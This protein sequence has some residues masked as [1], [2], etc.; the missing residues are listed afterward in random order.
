MGEVA[1]YVDE[2]TSAGTTD[3]V[4][5][6]TDEEL[7][8][9]GR[10]VRSDPAD[11]T[12]YEWWRT[13]TGP[14]RTGASPAKDGEPPDAVEG[15]FGTPGSSL[16]LTFAGGR[17]HESAFQVYGDSHVLYGKPSLI[18]LLHETPPPSG[19]RI[20]PQYEVYRYHLRGDL[21]TLR[22]QE[23]GCR[24]YSSKDISGKHWMR[25]E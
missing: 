19:R 11:L 21:L 8:V 20:C 1:C 5:A 2:G 12:L 22:L 4:I 3:S 13:E 7:L 14:W 23:G 17:Y 24:E 15:V 6:W 10:A 25:L 16:T 9:L 18:V